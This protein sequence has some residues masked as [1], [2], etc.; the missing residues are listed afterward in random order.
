[1]LA[2]RAKSGVA[3][4]GLLPLREAYIS[5]A[6]EAPYT[7][8]FPH[9]PVPATPRYTILP[10]RAESSRDEIRRTQFYTLIKK[11]KELHVN[12]RNA[13]RTALI[14]VH[15]IFFCPD[16]L[17]TTLSGTKGLLITSEPL[18]FFNMVS[19]S[20]YALAGQSL[21]T[22]TMAIGAASEMKGRA[23]P[24]TSE[25][26]SRRHFCSS[27]VNS[28]KTPTHSWRGSM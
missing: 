7:G 16:V 10:H 26:R 28:R 9:P 25:D 2:R 27:G 3:G 18:T 23:T 19:Y 8:R 13:V 15:T 1:M 12:Y 20:S 17:L 11:T 22:P 14:K 21:N 24:E 6:A 5:R 4:N